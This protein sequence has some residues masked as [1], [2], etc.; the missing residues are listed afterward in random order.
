VKGRHRILQ[1]R[2]NVGVEGRRD[3]GDVAVHKELA[4]GQADDLIGRDAVSAQPI[5]RYSGF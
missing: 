5:Q 1:H 3:I 2:M 4:G